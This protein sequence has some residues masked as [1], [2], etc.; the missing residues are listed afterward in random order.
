MSRHFAH[1]FRSDKLLDF[2]QVLF[3]VR[4]ARLHHQTSLSIVKNKQN[5]VSVKHS[6]VGHIKGQSVADLR[7]SSAADDTW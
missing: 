1:L 2:L 6:R 3:K 4:V 7:L 5:G